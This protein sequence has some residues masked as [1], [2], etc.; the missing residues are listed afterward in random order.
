MSIA[1]LNKIEK[2]FGRRVLFDKLDFNID[3]GERIGLIGDNGSG[4]TSLFKVIL[5]ELPIDAGSA[6]VSKGIRIGHLPQDPVFD[7]SNTVIDEAELAFATLHNL[8]HEQREIEHQMAH[9][10]GDELDRLLK[11]YQHVQHEFEI[12]G[13][14]AWRHRL[15]A[16]LLGVG[17]DRDSWE[18]NVGTLSGGQRS[19]LALAKLLTAQ[20][21]LLLL[22]EPTN[23][24]DL[25]AIAW[26]EE[27]L[28]DFNGAVLIIS[29]DRYLLD[30]MA[31]RIAWLTGA[32]LKTYPGN[33]SAFVT[34]RDLQELTQKRAFEEQQADIE[35]QAEFIRRFGAGQRSKEA[36]GRDKRLQ[37]LLRSDALLQDVAGTKKIHVSLGTD[38]RAGDRVLK[39]KELSKSYDNKPLWKDID[40]E[41]RRAER[42][43]IIGPNGSGKT[44][45][46]EVLLGRRDADA[47]EIR[48]GANLNIGYY[49]QRLG[50]LDPESTVAEEVRGDREISPGDLRSVL[51]MML[52]RRE[53]IDKPIKMLSG[54]ERA[55]VAMAQLLVD[56]PNVLVMDEPTNHLDIQS[57]E[58]LES[59]LAGFAGTIICVSHDRYFLD[60]IINRL[61][62]LKPPEMIQFSGNYTAWATRQAQLA[63]EARRPKTPEPKESKPRPN[64]PPKKRPDNA[65]ARPLGRLTVK[66]LEQQITETEIALAEFENLFAD[67]GLARDSQRAKKLNDDFAALGKKLK[68]LEQEYFTRNA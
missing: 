33:Y 30:R 2:T 55:R 5:G 10:L 39:V 34:Q 9:V 11:R 23:H 18:Q 17:L 25:A 19:R 50:D 12:A 45:L 15:E 52:F 22:D 20:N 16:A 42:V 8:S 36:K 4:K 59:A 65:W 29:H 64:L 51:A 62:I 24:L 38:Q 28:A 6:A 47:G 31:N 26:V 1:T 48:W 63:A 40:L 66:E 27:Y 35:K 44:T 56:R 57:C 60:K 32:R 3:R 41:I 49:D 46:L 58:A 53:E 61:F 13:G 68:Q 54:G 67:V 37:R 7:P 14:Y 21:D 43:G